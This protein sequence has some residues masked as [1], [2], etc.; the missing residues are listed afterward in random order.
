MPRM[1]R[2]STLILLLVTS[3]FAALQSDTSRPQASI[4]PQDSQG[5]GSQKAPKND[6]AAVPGD[7]LQVEPV[8]IKKADYPIKAANEGL[9][10][11]VWVKAFITEAG[12]VERVEVISGDP[13]LAEAAVKAAKEWKFKP[14]IRGGKPIKIVTKIPFDFAFRNEVKDTPAPADPPPDQANNAGGAA[15]PQRVLVSQG[16]STGLLI[17]KVQ[18]IYPESARRNHVQGTV[19]LRAVITKDGR[20]SE[21]TPISGPKELIPAAVGAVQQWRYKPYRLADR[22]VEVL[23]QVVVNFT[24]SGW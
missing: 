23:T 3:G 20:I 11:Q 4:S 14:F 6:G 2:G 22:P 15:A 17:H 10:G 5:S 19:I 9:Q 13:T 18:P 21:L 12:D 8:K 24:L 16:V 1:L 7:S